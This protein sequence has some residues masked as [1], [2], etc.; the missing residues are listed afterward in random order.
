MS[1]QIIATE[2]AFTDTEINKMNFLET[3]PCSI[4]YNYSTEL[5]S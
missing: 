4:Q 1:R 5:S 3:F 2:A